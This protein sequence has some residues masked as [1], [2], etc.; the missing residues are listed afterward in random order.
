[1]NSDSLKEILRNLSPENQ[2]LLEIIGLNVL[3]KQIFDQSVRVGKNLPGPDKFEALTHGLDSSSKLKIAKR[4]IYWKQKT[5]QLNWTEQLGWQRS[6][7]TSKFKSSVGE[8]CEWPGCENTDHLTVDHRFPYSL[9]G[10]TDISNAQTLCRTCNLA[11][12]NSIYS[13]NQWPGE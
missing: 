13:I 12:S 11:K 8:I 7:Q 2:Q 5:D 10:D 4:L 1:L 3:T 9:G 6:R